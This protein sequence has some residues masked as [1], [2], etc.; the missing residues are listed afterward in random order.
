MAE[1]ECQPQPP[2]G[3]AA[4]LG[5]APPLA[6]FGGQA[7]GAMDKDHRRL[8][9]V[10]VL[11]PRSAAASAGL[12][13]FI[14]ERGGGQCGGMHRKPGIVGG[15]WCGRLLR[16]EETSISNKERIP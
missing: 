5:L 11:P 14:E 10:A 6:P 15:P 12:V 4:I 1:R 2:Q 7:G 9:L 13:T 3:H 8:D 16:F